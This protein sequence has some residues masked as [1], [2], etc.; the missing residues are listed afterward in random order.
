MNSTAIIADIIASIEAGEFDHHLGDIQSAVFTRMSAE[1][2]EKHSAHGRQAPETSAWT[3]ARITV[4]DR[5]RVTGLTGKWGFLNNRVAL[6]EKVNAKTVRIRSFVRT[7]EGQIINVPRSF[8]T[9]TEDMPDSVNGKL[10]NA[11][12]A[13][14]ATATQTDLSKFTVGEKV[15]VVGLSGNINN[16]IVELL[17]INRT[18]FVI[19]FGEKRY[20]IP[21]ECAVPV[22]TEPAS[23]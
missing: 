19:Q 21:M 7:A 20:T 11:D 18:R 9:L 8:V 16:Q 5:V 23:L 12:L 15:R 10:D 2:A 22:E 17:K 13:A 6:V 14:V 3:A 4:G 1:S